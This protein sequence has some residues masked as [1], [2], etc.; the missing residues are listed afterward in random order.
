M[1]SDSP[2]QNYFFFTLEIFRQNKIRTRPYRLNNNNRKNRIIIIERVSCIL[3]L[4]YFG[5]MSSKILS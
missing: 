1:F 4:E 3:V 2:V 5:I